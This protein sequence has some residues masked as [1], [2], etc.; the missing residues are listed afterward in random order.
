VVIDDER[1]PVWVAALIVVA[2]VA[3]IAY[4]WLY[5]RARTPNRA[6]AGR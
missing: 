3:L 5:M 1:R 4:W 2:P 6:A